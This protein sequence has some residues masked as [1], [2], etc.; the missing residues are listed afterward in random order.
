VAGEHHSLL[1]T[2]DG[3][4]FSFG[5]N[6]NGRTGLGTTLGN[7]LVATAIDTTNLGARKITQMAASNNQS[8]LLADDG[9]VFAMGSNGFSE[10][11]LGP[12]V[13]SAAIATPIDASNLGGRKI[14]QV[15]AGSLHGLLLADDG[16]VFSFGK[17]DFGITGQG[18]DIGQTE[19]A[20]PIDTSLLGGK[21]ITHITSGWLHNLLLAEDGTVF[22]FGLNSG[23]NTGLGT[24]DGD[25]Q[26]ATPIVTTNLTGLVV[27]KLSGGGNF[28]LLLAVPEPGT[29]ALLL[30]ASLSIIISRRRLAKL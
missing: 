15:A 26:V 25:T 8:L 16:T 7:T 18:T 17:N 4:V 19:V 14:T 24:G 27:T 29:A 1:L 10:A 2:D 5:F 11:G 20:T 22:A 13:P 3:T 23:G 12:G 9:S 6:G 21:K 30:G 28:S